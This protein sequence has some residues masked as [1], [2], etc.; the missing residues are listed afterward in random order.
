MHS[1]MVSIW[2]LV[3]TL[4]LESHM[5]EVETRTCG[6]GYTEVPRSRLRC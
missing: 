5:G 6:V 1:G 2:L 4:E 3:M